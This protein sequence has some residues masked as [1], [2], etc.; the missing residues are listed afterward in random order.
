MEKK[1]LPAK[2]CYSH[3]GGKL[4]NLLLIAFVEKQWIKRSEAHKDHYYITDKG[5]KELTRLGVDL[6]QIREE[7]M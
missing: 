7:L 6:S 5:K 3:I 1:H 2:T 4:G